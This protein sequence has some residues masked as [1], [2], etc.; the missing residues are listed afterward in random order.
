VVSCTLLTS[1]LYTYYASQIG[2]S[3]LFI[4]NFV[5]VIFVVPCILL[6]IMLHPK[7]FG[8]N[9]CNGTTVVALTELTREDETDQQHT[10]VERHT[11]INESSYASSPLKNVPAF[12]QPQNSGCE[13]EGEEERVNSI[14]ILLPL[15]VHNNNANNVST[16][17][18]SSFTTLCA[19]FFNDPGNNGGDDDEHFFNSR[20]KCSDDVDESGD[21]IFNDDSSSNTSYCYCDE[22]SSSDGDY[23]DT[24]DVGVEC[25]LKRERV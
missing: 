13:E 20:S 19:D 1:L 21:G 15:T 4:A 24:A 3:Y 12:V 10:K 22:V 17:G 16:T 23:N 6:K 9:N 2:D 25:E 11:T 5:S 14:T 18:E 8:E 7:L